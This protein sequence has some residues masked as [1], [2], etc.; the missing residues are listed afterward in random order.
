[1]ELTVAHRQSVLDWYHLRVGEFHSGLLRA[2]ELA[3]ELNLPFQELQIRG[4]LLDKV[5]RDGRID[6][7]RKQ[8]SGILSATRR[9]GMRGDV[10]DFPILWAIVAVAEGDWRRA[11]EL[12]RPL[13]VPP[14]QGTGGFPLIASIEVEYRTG[15]PELGREHLTRL[16]DQ[17][18]VGEGAFAQVHA[19]EYSGW[20]AYVSGDVGELTQ[21]AKRM[22]LDLL[23]SPPNPISEVLGHL[24]LGY[25]GLAEHDGPAAAAHYE[26]LKDQ[27]LCLFGVAGVFADLLGALARFCGKLDEA[28]GHL[29]AALG[30]FGS[31]RP[32]STWL[33]CALG[34]TLLERGGTGDR[35]RAR[36]LLSQALA[37]AR[38]LGMPPIEERAAR[39][40]DCVGI[41]GR[42]PH[43]AGLTEREVEVLRLVAKGGTNKEIASELR[44]SVKTVHTHLANI[45]VKCEV[46]NRTEAAAFAT[47]H[48][49]V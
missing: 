38:E 37:G 15:H 21:E 46:G 42:E 16:V 12:L 24:G 29:E 14:S 2:L 35:A 7:A 22:A 9:M 10:N 18:R 25:F 28:V 39:A 48:S 4:V 19:V 45:F 6:Q 5:L 8:L 27:P 23:A 43:P 20:A 47:K 36:E 30:H 33:S 40:L 26:R 32:T 3:Q 34:E 49:L 31:L 13:L 1:L 44:I 17:S 11:R 41:G